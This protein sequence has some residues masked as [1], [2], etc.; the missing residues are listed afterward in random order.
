M[1]EETIHQIFENAL[2]DPELFSTM[3]IETLLDSIENEKNEY[4]DEKTMGDITQD[5]YETIS[6]VYSI[7]RR[8]EICNKLVGYRYVDLLHELHKG[9]HVRWIRHNEK[10]DKMNIQND[11]GPKLTNGGIVADIKFLDNGTHVLCKNAMGRFIQY[12][13]DDC[14][15]FQKLSVDEQLILMAYEHI[16]TKNT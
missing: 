15:T 16:S 10:N 14:Y 5:I 7:E 6:E 8:E 2:K 1:N 12:K 4:L 11:T 9:K 13:F 3:D